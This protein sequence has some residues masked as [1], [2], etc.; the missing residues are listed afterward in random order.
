MHI[1]SVAKSDEKITFVDFMIF[2]GQ[3]PLYKAS[4]LTFD[5]LIL[6]DGP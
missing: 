1:S 6:V 3:V 4:T 5:T 2:C